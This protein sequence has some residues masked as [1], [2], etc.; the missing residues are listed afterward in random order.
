MEMQKVIAQLSVSESGLE[1]ISQNFV[2][3]SKSSSCK[4][5]NFEKMISERMQGNNQQNTEKLINAS[6]ARTVSDK[7][8]TEMLRS[9]NP[10]DTK[11]GYEV[12]ENSQELQKEQT[13]FGKVDALNQEK[14]VVSE[15]NED[16]KG[17]ICEELDITSGELEVIMSQLG[18]QLAD[19]QDVSSLQQLVL[20]VSGESDSMLLLT[21]ET[22]GEKLQ[23]LMKNISE[24]TENV[25]EKFDV[26]DDNISQ[27]LKNSD[28]VLE[29][30]VEQISSEGMLEM[31]KQMQLPLSFEVVDTQE[32]ITNE[33]RLVEVDETMMAQI[34]GEKAS[35][36]NEILQVTKNDLKSKQGLLDVKQTELQEMV[37]TEQNV[38]EEQ[39]EDVMD[40]DPMA[41]EGKEV[42]SD[43]A[44]VT[45]DLSIDLS[46]E[47]V[48]LQHT[49]QKKD[50]QADSGN[51]HSLFEQFM[52]GLTA[53]R[54]NVTE[55]VSMKT[56]VVEQMREI[57]E[58]VVEQIKI[59]VKPD[60]S[61]MEI[62]LNPENLGKVNLSVVAKE[63]H[64]TAQFVTETELA[65][66]AL[67]GQIQQL[68]ETLGEQGLKVDEVE[69]TVSNFDFSQ[70]NQANAEEH[71]QQQQSMFSK[72]M[73]R[74]LNINSIED[75]EDLTEGEQLAAKIMQLNGNQVDYTA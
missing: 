20:T 67:E 64:I 29:N 17:Q 13:C 52:S 37:I 16:V 61:A 68:R 75:L 59:T 26:S 51:E 71:K 66:H 39:T 28:F 70:S 25:Q 12:V 27:I 5:N 53:E 15:W 1:S 9:S 24:I 44:I 47:E 21:N 32:P 34:T 73:V 41:F 7:R 14:E 55:D 18:L 2:V 54:V 62:Q 65:K 8:Q 45:D 31:D 48:E 42:K 49:P 40:V 4:N 3:A 36:D 23:H 57:V 72:R 38:V 63:G 6:S 10:I 11:E 35:I 19:L 58:Q 50:T 46:V 69:V 22:L 74:N 43:K 33:D 30:N 60:T 56:A